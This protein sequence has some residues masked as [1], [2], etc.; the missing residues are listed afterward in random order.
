MSR[1]PQ[2]SSGARGSL[3]HIQEYVN[4]RSQDLDS[5]IHSASGGRISLPI[6]WRS[7]LAADEYSEYRDEDFLQRL[8][9]TLPE[10]SLS[11]FWP[12]LGPQWDAL[13]LD[14]SGDAVLVEAKANIPEIVSD[15]SRAQGKSREQ[16]ESSL[17][18]TAAFLG[19]KPPGDWSGTFYQYTN[20][21]AHLCLLHQFNGISTWLVYVYFIGDQD[22][23]G[24]ESEAEWRAAI[25]VLHGALGLHRHALLN[26]VVDVFLDVRT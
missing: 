2:P 7:P 18:E 17:E 11:S 5:A 15:P 8:G 12:R 19:A 25:Q 6:D 3:R 20:R 26:R 16:I 10:R 4:N 22:V 23:G 1:H 13:G 9:L 24:P 21:L 14:A